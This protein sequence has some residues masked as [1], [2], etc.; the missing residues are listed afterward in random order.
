MKDLIEPLESW[1]GSDW[2]WIKQNSPWCREGEV[3]DLEHNYKETIE[4]LIEISRVIIKGNYATCL[5][6]TSDNI[7]ILEDQLGKSW[8]ELREE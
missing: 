8:E 3:R 5:D 6:R 1:I 4:A 2:E 7:M